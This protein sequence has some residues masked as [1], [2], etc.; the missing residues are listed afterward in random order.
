MDAVEF[1]T[2]LGD[3]EVAFVVDRCYL[4]QPE[5]E[6]FVGEWTWGHR[7]TPDFAR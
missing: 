6:E 2:L 3:V 4:W 5:T 7:M 1:R